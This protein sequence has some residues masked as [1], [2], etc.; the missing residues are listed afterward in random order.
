MPCR[1]IHLR[2]GRSIRSMR[3]PGQVTDVA[4][5]EG[6]QLDRRLPDDRNEGERPSHAALY[7]GDDRA[8]RAVLS[9]RALTYSASTLSALWGFPSSDV[10]AAHAA[11]LSQ[12]R[13]FHIL[14]RGA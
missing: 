1:S 5:Q 2:R 8:P 3:L 14:R 11:D 9:H 4:L 6:A 7:I 12:S 13:A 10:A